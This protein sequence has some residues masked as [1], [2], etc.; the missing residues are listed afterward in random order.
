MRLHQWKD[1]NPVFSPKEAW[2]SPRRMDYR[3]LYMQYRLRLII[4]KPMIIHC[5]YEIVGHSKT[6]WHHKDGKGRADDFH[7]LDLDFEEGWEYIDRYW[8][9]GAGRYPNWNNPGYHVDTGPYR[10]W[11]K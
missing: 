9:G 2:G 3:L 5:G 8:M 10:R 11:E 1:F 6:S 7:I 4:G